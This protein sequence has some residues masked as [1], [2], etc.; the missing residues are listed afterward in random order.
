MNMLM[1]ASFCLEL[2]GNFKY[3]DNSYKDMIQYLRKVEFDGGANFDCE[4]DDSVL[5]LNISFILSCTS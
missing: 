4:H 5:L 1:F 2:R 3:T